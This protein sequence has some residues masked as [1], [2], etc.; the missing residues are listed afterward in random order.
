MSDSGIPH[1]FIQDRLEV[2]QAIQERKAKKQRQAAECREARQAAADG[3][4]KG[5]SPLKS[6]SPLSLPAP[7]M[8]PLPRDSGVADP[9]SYGGGLVVVPLLSDGGVANPMSDGGG[10]PIAGP[11][12]QPTFARPCAG[13]LVPKLPQSLSAPVAHAGRV[14]DPF[15]DENMEK[16]LNQFFDEMQRAKDQVLHDAIQIASMVTEMISQ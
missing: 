13:A 2:F 1:N 9:M 5:S 12:G 11:S 4:A 16:D 3:A 10:T 6:S 8:P 7:P 15:M 14:S